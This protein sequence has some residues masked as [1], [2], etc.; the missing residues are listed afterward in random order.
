MALELSL[1]MSLN[2]LLC[3]F[4][5]W[6]FKN[7]LHAL[8]NDNL[9]ELTCIKVLPQCLKLVFYFILF[10]E[11]RDIRLAVI[12]SVSLVFLSDSGVNFTC[13][14]MAIFRPFSC[15][16]TILISQITVFS[17]APIYS[18]FHIYNHNP[19]EHNEY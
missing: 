15:L 7:L 3:K 18:H 10:L 8:D 2:F 5:N 12:R 1:N 13:N 19:S 4:L 6:H 14:N 17:T 16:Y 9:N 11:N